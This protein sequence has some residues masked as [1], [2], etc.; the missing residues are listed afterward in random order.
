MN[1]PQP[2]MQ[3]KRLSLNA[4]VT[5]LK[6]YWFDYLVLLLV[7]VIIVT[8]DQL[9]KVW[10]RANVPLGGDWLPAQLALLMPFARI[11]FWYNSGAAFGIFANG[12]YLFMVLAIIVAGAIL[13]YFPRVSRKDWWLRLALMLQFSGAVG[14]LTDR[15]QFGHVTDFIS[16]GNFAIFNIADA[17]ISVGVAVLILGVWITEMAEK[18]RAAAQKVAAP[19]PDEGEGKGE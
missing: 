9:A 19:S 1:V 8:S 12:N 7:A 10:V 11:R 18:R 15:I 14:N 6:N 2:A 16:V 13:Y 4:I 17:S 5:F 3:P